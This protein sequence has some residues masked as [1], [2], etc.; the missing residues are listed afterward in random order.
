MPAPAAERSLARTASISEPS[1]ARAQLRHADGDDDEDDQDEEPE[2]H[3][4]EVGADLGRRS[5]PNSVGTGDVLAARADVL[6]LRNQTASIATPRAR[7]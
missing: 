6:G 2:L 5:R 3:A 1:G 4:G 7:A